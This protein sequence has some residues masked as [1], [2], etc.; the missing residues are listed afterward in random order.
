MV[1][2]IT[3][4][5]KSH[6]KEVAFKK[7]DIKKENLSKPIKKATPLKSNKVQDAPK[8]GKESNVQLEKK[9]VQNKE[10]AIKEE[11]DQPPT[12]IEKPTVEEL[13]T[14]KDASKSGLDVIIQMEENSA[15][16]ESK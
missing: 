15:Q 11:N 13:E 6:G 10:T 14:I 3:K 2:T 8:S 12:P 7:T 4:F 1:E 5:F 16:N 9:S